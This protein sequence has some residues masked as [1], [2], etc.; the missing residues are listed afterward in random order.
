MDNE[1]WDEK[2]GRERWKTKLDRVRRMVEEGERKRTDGE[3]AR[4]REGER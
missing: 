3:R 2:G 1:T 4:G